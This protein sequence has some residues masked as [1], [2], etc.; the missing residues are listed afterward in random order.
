MVQF[1]V[2]DGHIELLEIAIGQIAEVRVRNVQRAPV[3][4]AQMA[5]EN[6]RHLIVRRHFVAGDEGVQIRFPPTR[7]R[8]NFPVHRT[9]GRAHRQTNDRQQE[10]RHGDGVSHLIL[11]P[12]KN[13]QSTWNSTVLK[14]ITVGRIE[15]MG[16]IICDRRRRQSST[17]P[18]VC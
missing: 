15:L 16:N 10:C 3:R 6:V 11:T 2:V 13:V 18:E 14:G 1:K 5:P 7:A 4:G 12:Y 17:E 8:H 9:P